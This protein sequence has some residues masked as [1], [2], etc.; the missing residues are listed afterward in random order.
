MNALTQNPPGQ[1]AEHADNKADF[2]LQQI[3]ADVLASLTPEQLAA[4]RK[5]VK[6]SI[7][8]ASPKLV[9]LR[10]NIDLIFT[11]FFVVLFVGK[12]R[13]KNPRAHTVSGMMAITNKVAALAL[14]LGLNLTVSAFIFL[15]A[16]LIKSSLGINLFPYHLR[17]YL[18]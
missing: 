17:D 2:I 13:R 3:D 16:Y 12:E 1:Q 15:L 4:V 10:I 8:Q 11:R 14:L 9:D 5:M 18:G 6:S 7:L